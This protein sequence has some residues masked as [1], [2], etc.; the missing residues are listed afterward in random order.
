MAVRTRLRTPASLVASAINP[1]PYEA[2][3]RVRTSTRARAVSRRPFCVSIA[4]SIRASV[5]ATF[6]E[7][8]IASAAVSRIS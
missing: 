8:P 5:A 1:S 2:N 3:A 6:C 4:R 7:I